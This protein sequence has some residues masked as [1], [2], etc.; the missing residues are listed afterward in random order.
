MHLIQKVRRKI[1]K[2]SINRNQDSESLLDK[3]G[4]SKRRSFHAHSNCQSSLEDQYSSCSIT[5]SVS[6]EESSS[7]LL[8][9]LDEYNTQYEDSY[10]SQSS[11]NSSVSSSKKGLC[12]NY[13]EYKP[14]KCRNKV[15]GRPQEEAYQFQSD[16]SH[17]F[18]NTQESSLALV[19]YRSEV[20]S[21]ISDNHNTNNNMI[22]AVT[23]E[24]ST[25]NNIEL[26]Q[27]ADKRLS[28][29]SDESTTSSIPVEDQQTLELHSKLELVSDFDRFVSFFNDTISNLCESP[30]SN[31][32]F[33][34]TA[35]S[36]FNFSTSPDHNEKQQVQAPSTPPSPP[37]PAAVVTHQEIVE[38]ET[39]TTAITTHIPTRSV[40][41][42]AD[43]NGL[44]HIFH[45]RLSTLYESPSEQE[46]SN[47]NSNNINIKDQQE[48]TTSISTL[49]DE[50]IIKA[51]WA[52][53]VEM[54]TLDAHCGFSDAYEVA[55][56]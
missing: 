3:K 5:A 8:E 13:V 36:I 17:G 56:I 11:S 54:M 15:R 23:S 43:E 37:S 40:D 25:D 19:P 18:K 31:N 9:D 26:I 16:E 42:L 49:E 45:D 53:A 10:H 35:S 29:S 22:V 38:Y 50:D 28:L 27:T 21:H 44:V 24:E 34:S 33:Q 48:H 2:S 51:R 6:S 4:K 47:I 30:V 20:V 32:Y 39:P 52:Y 55:E 7:L 14:L 41:A 46:N 1:R 12:S